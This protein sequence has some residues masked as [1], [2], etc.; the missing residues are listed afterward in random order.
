MSPLGPKREPCWKS[1]AVSDGDVLTANAVLGQSAPSSFW[2]G[3]PNACLSSYLFDGH[4][5]ATLILVARTPKRALL[6]ALTHADAHLASRKALCLLSRPVQSSDFDPSLVAQFQFSN[7]GAGCISVLRPRQPSGASLLLYHV[8]KRRIWPKT[9]RQAGCSFSG[10]EDSSSRRVP[11]L[12]DF[13]WQYHN[14]KP[15]RTCE[16]LVGRRVVVAGKHI[17]FSQPVSRRE[18]NISCT[19]ASCYGRK[20]TDTARRGRDYIAN[21][22]DK[23]LSALQREGK[24]KISQPFARSRNSLPLTSG[25]HSTETR[26]ISLLALGSTNAPVLRCRVRGTRPDCSRDM[27]APGEL[28]VRQSVIDTCRQLH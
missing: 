15:C 2:L 6:F 26:S 13:Q 11:H 23:P 1:A 14:T 21:H 9:L 24:G 27:F 7:F 18:A 4:R 22:A 20:L 3:R 19:H 10:G 5:H 8:E 12:S 25:P 28:P 16:Q 17:V